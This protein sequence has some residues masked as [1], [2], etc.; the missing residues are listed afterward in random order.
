MIRARPPGRGESDI[1]MGEI[2]GAISLNRRAVASLRD[3]MTGIVILPGE[4]GYDEARTLFNA[5]IDKRPQVI[6]QCESTEDVVAAVRFGRE[7]G[8][9]I[10]VRGG[11]HGVAGTALTE[12]GLTID[13]RRMH[14]VTV[15]PVER[16]ATV[17]GGAVTGDLDRAT[18]PYALAT[19]AGRVSTTGMGG[20][21]LGGGS[22]WLER[23]FGLACDNL[24]SVELVT[25]DGDVVTASDREHR[26]LFWALHGGGGNFGVAT[27]FRMRL[28]PLPAITAALF[29]WP[30]ET[31]PFIARA[32]RDFIEQAPDDVGGGMIYMT[33]PPE[34]FVPEHL[35]GELVCG[36]LVTYTGPEAEA[37]DLVAP[38]A[39]LS[40]AG[41]MIA[42]LPY[43]E[44][45]CM[46]DDPPG[47]RNYWSAEY[48]GTLAD[49]AIDRFCARAEDMI[50]PSRSQ[51]VI[52][53]QGGAVAR[54]PGEYPIPWRRAPW[55]VH[56]FGMWEDPLD[57]ERGR[58]WA[59]DV[60]ADM[61]PWSIGAVY[62]NFIGNEGEE[63][64]IAGIGPENHRRLVAVKKQY[65]P[66]NA[67]HLN[68][69]I[70]P[71]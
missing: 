68:Q 63:R 24:L 46:L 38:M 42:E 21:T 36:M 56:P 2:M 53:P 5:M 52:F 19:T 30:A 54:G 29:L 39:A 57:D 35:I 1:A 12:G 49:P 59:K 27:S 37:R 13:L 8:L 43:A 25:A 60:V 48:L 23:K 7:A 55:A 70:K 67:F 17:P 41:Q 40:P 33:G 31:G 66:D 15:D 47:F 14:E 11:G 51:H 9:E 16:V 20:F 34:P 26:D 22:G 28:H 32:Y 69:N 62:L 58:Q 50:V 6:A 44:L 64:V 18:Q 61:E 3:H 71:R 45:Q 10:S 65:D 4:P